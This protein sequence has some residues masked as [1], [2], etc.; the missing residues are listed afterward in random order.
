MDYDDCSDAEI[1][2]EVS[3]VLNSEY[4]EIGKRSLKELLEQVKRRTMEKE[5]LPAD[6]ESTAVH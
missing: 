4:R 2:D 1:A 3:R 6:V 5:L